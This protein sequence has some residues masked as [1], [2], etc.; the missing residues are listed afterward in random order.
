LKNLPWKCPNSDYPKSANDPF[1]CR[2]HSSTLR[3]FTVH[4]GRSYRHCP[5]TEPDN[6]VQRIQR[7]RGRAHSR[8]SEKAPNGFKT[9]R[10][11]SRE[12][13]TGDKP[14]T[15]KNERVRLLAALTA[16][17]Q[18]TNH[19]F[20][21]RPKRWIFRLRGAQCKG[22]STV[23]GFCSLAPDNAANHC[24]NCRAD[25]IPSHDQSSSVTG[26]ELAL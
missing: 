21:R 23:A 20:T 26:V 22:A 8:R 24:Q 11:R 1:P 6:T 15:N 14:A 19:R 4:C 3:R 7:S 2:T 16:T 5:S 18:V 13:C 9:V 10:D 17:E 12:V 25:Q